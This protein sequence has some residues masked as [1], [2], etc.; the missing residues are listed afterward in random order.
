MFGE[1][2][3]GN[4]RAMSLIHA[5]RVLVIV[6]LLANPFNLALAGRR[7]IKRT[8]QVLPGALRLIN[9]L[10]LGVL[11][12]RGL[13]NR[14][15]F[16]YV[17]CHNPRPAA[18]DGSFG[19]YDRQFC[20]PARRPRRSG[21]RSILS[22]SGLALNMWGLRLEEIR[23]DVAWPVWGSAYSY[24][25]CSRLG[26]VGFVVHYDRAPA[27]EAGPLACAGWAGGTCRDGVDCGGRYGVCS[28]TPPVSN[29]H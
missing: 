22:R 1:E 8:G 13:E 28:G 23:K 5:T 21:R 29:I 20:R 24:C 16:R 27:V 19:E 18:S 6:V 7:L 11:R 12:H 15:P 17:W 26:I 25:C 14:R 2:A 10:T 3:G 9:W 4:V